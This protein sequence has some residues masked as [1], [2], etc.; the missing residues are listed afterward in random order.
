MIGKLFTCNKAKKKKKV[1]KEGFEP[2]VLQVI[3]LKPEV[4]HYP[5]NDNGDSMREF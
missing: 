3:H 4:Y 2:K 5:N 1:S